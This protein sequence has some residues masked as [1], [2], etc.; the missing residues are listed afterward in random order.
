MEE[1][2]WFELLGEE[3][4]SGL[5]FRPMIVHAVSDFCLY[6]FVNKF[7]IWGYANLIE[8]NYWGWE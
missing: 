8:P 6:G 1:W 3:L 2:D 7:E 4:I 5:G